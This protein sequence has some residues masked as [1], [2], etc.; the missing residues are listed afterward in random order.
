MYKD[1]IYRLLFENK[2]AM[3]T[4]SYTGLHASMHASGTARINAR[5]WDCTHHCTH[6][7]ND[8]IKS[9]SISP[10]Q[11]FTARQCLLRQHVPFP[12]RLN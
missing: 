10:A 9:Q 4:Q 5:I 6:R 7:E 3:K 1:T 2:L 12:H 11:E 8:H